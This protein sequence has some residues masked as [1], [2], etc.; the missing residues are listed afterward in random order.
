MATQSVLETTLNKTWG[1]SKGGLPIA[2]VLSQS[3]LWRGFIL[4]AK[5]EDHTEL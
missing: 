3:H 4:L 1:S 2:N 5:S